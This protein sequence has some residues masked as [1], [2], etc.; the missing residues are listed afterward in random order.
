M[1]RKNGMILGFTEDAKKWNK[2]P[3]KVFAVN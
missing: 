1:M 2:E 3:P